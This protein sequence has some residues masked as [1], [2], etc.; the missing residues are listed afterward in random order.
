MIFILIIIFLIVAIYISSNDNKNVVDLSSKNSL[1]IDPTEKIDN[2]NK[3]ELTSAKNPA[4]N[5]PSNYDDKL[6]KTITIPISS[7]KSG[8]SRRSNY[9]DYGYDSFRTNSYGRYADSSY[10]EDVGGP[11][12]TKY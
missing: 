1:D 7:N 8:Y 12:K 5:N 2:A 3:T 10:R 4:I 9:S 11:R 6:G